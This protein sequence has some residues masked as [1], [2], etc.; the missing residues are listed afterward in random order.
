ME[1]TCFTCSKKFSKSPSQ[2]ENHE[3]PFCS[4]SCAAKYNNKERPKRKRKKKC[5]ECES[6]VLSSQTYCSKECKN[7]NKKE[8]RQ[9]KKKTEKQDYKRKRELNNMAVTAYRQRQKLQ[10]IE[11]KKGKCIL[12]GYKT[13][14]S[15]LT[16]HHLDPT[17]KERQISSGNTVRWET[18][19]KELD[20]CVLLCMNCHA[21]VHAGLKIVPLMYF[22][23]SGAYPIRTG[24]TRRDKPVR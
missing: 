3:H 15:A 11:Y 2:V 1:F 13:C 20:K 21:E 6:L 5:K 4:Q 9:K 18:M 23:I 8:K 16:F 12:C 24:E 19:K 10:A 17:K 22:I 14:P 7:K